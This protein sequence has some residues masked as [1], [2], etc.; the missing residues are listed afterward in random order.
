MSTSRM[1]SS[2]ARKPAW[3]MPCST[4]WRAATARTTSRD[5]LVARPSEDELIARYFAPLA[6]YHGADRLADDAALYAPPAGMSLV[7][8]T[9]AL[10][11]SVHFL[12]DDPPDTIA[13]K[14]LRV[15][16]SDL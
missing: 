7:V 4:S 3:S 1:L 6:T 5:E 9:D 14:A 15:N 10:V 16:L 2:T 12:A 8:T 13:R 11:A